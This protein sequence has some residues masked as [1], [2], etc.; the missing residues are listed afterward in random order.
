[1]CFED[2]YVR[3]VGVP[4]P[5]KDNN[6]DTEPYR[7]KDFTF[8]PFFHLMFMHFVIAYNDFNKQPF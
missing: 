5:N 1:M 2:V 7:P 6:Y 4:I 3:L 8:A